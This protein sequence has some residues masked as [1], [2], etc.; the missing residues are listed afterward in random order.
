MSAANIIFTL[1]GTDLIVQCTTKDKMKVICQKYATKIGINMNSLVFLYGGNQINLDLSFKEQANSIDRG[2]NKMQVLVYKN[3]DDG[4]ICP[5]CGEKIVE[6][7][8]DK[9]DEIISS[10]NNIKDNIDGAKLII[11]NIIRI[12]SLN[13]VNVQLK[14]INIILNTINEDISKNIIKLKNLLNENKNE[15]IYKNIIDGM[16]NIQPNEINTDIIL[17]NTDIND[18]IEV[19]LNNKK[20][21]M[22]KNATKRIIDYKFKR[23]GNY[24]FKIIINGNITN[25]NGFFEDCSNIISLDLSNLNTSEVIDM[26]RMFHNCKNLKEIKE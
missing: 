7:K 3:E 9:I 8:T 25:L 24:I 12:S 19:Y 11:D 21:N 4:F 15:K 6:L 13:S 5:K 26:Y 1:D 16:L 18:K 10:I 20:I 23:E 14:N 17:F 2:R 22:I